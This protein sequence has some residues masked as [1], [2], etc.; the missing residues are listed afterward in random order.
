MPDMTWTPGIPKR[1]KDISDA[2]IRRLFSHTSSSRDYVPKVKVQ[3][4]A[5]DAFDWTIERPDCMKVRD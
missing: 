1:L 2:D 5:P 4:D 3:A